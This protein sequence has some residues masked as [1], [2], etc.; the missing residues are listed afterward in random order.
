MTIHVEL[1][2]TNDNGKDLRQLTDYIRKETC[3]DSKGWYRLGSTLYPMGQFHK[4]DQAY[5]ILLE[6]TT[7]ENEKAPIYGQLESTKTNQG[8]YKEAI[9]FYEP[10]VE[11]YKKIFHRMFLI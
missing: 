5:Q 4:S 8:Q 6:Q 7:N 10:A 9:T 1:T 2:L 11:I 3:P